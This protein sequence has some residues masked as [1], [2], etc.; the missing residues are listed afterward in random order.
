M[1]PPGHGPSS[2][3][4]PPFA[5]M[6]SFGGYVPPPEEPSPR[7][8][9]DRLKTIGRRALRH[10]KPA[11]AIVAL[12]S[13]ASVVLAL[14]QK[15]I[16]RSEC[17]VLYRLG[18]GESEESGVDRVMHLAPRLRQV[19]TTRARLE[20]VVRDF[21]LYP[22][23]VESRGM[24][25]AVDEARDHIEVRGRDSETFFLSFESDS[26]ETAQHV[27]QRL[28]DDMIKEFESQKVAQA[29]QRASFVAREQEQA[30]SRMDEA[31]KALST[32]ASDHPVMA[33]TVRGS[34]PGSADLLV[35][36]QRGGQAAGTAAPSGPSLQGGAQP[37]TNEP[38]LPSSVAGVLAQLT[39][40]RDEA[41]ARVGRA[42][43]ELQEKL[44][45]YTDQHPDV[46]AARSELAIAQRALDT[47][48]GRLE[49]ARAEAQLAAP[50]PTASP[51]KAKAR[52]T[53]SVRAASAAANV[54]KAVE[55]P[56]NEAELRLEF[57][58]RLRAVR[59]ARELYAQ[60]RETLEKANLELSAAQA[61]A[62]ESMAI[63]D[64]ANLP[65]KPFKGGRSKIALGG[66]V[67]SLVLAIAYALASVLFDDRVRDASDLRQLGLRPPLG[68]VPRIS[69]APRGRR[70]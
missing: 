51:T 15:L 34:M 24:G 67:L 69:S 53:A 60:R 43:Q 63:L 16:F 61:A 3:S 52:S 27:T 59:D 55:P 21:E 36:S 33:A 12:G 4:I 32:F 22:R 8:R 54:P 9:I 70:G 38:A 23:I 2:P 29:K 26:R 35:T 49:R 10:W 58:R 40:A 11:L 46:V 44:A 47:A 30:E 65:T 13:A 5:S 25:E 17:V 41:A 7:E 57:E 18:K 64:P 31:E 42:Q 66:G 14:Q 45:G 20:S 39:A 28:A 6:P 56:A 68:V 48:N 37:S 19:L 1:P 50:P 62:N